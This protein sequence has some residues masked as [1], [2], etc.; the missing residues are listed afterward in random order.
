MLDELIDDN[1]P[2]TNTT[3]EKSPIN[4]T[5]QVTN[6][7]TTEGRDTYYYINILNLFI[8]QCCA[9]VEQSDIDFTITRV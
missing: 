5:W 6:Q 4:W 9:V 2:E 1:V 3:V 7:N 8:L